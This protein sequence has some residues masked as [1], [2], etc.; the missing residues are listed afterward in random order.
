[1]TKNN[2]TLQCDERGAIMLLGLFFA[3][4]GAAIVYSVVGVSQALLYRQGL[5]DGADAGA[6]SAAVME[7]RLM[8]AIVLVNIL[9][10]AILSVLVALK[11]VELLAIMGMMLATALAYP[12]FGASLAAIPVLTPIQQNV[13]S[14]HDQLEDPISEGIKA[15]YNVNFYLREYGP[16]GIVGVVKDEFQ[17]Q[18]FEHPVEEG[19]LIGGDV[20]PIEDGEYS[21]LC[22]KAAKFPVAMAGETLMKPLAEAIP[23]VFAALESGMELMAE[24]FSEWF[25]GDGESGSPSMSQTEE[26]WYPQSK[27]LSSCQDSVQNSYSQDWGAAAE[28][29][30]EAVDCTSQAADAELAQPDKV[31]NCV[32]QCD[33]DGPYE[34]R[35]QLAREVC[36]PKS[37][38]RWDEYSY[39]VVE[40]SVLYEWT[41]QGW[42]RHEPDYGPVRIEDS[43]K[44]LCG[45]SRAELDPGYNPIVRTTDDVNDLDVVC[46]SERPPESEARIGRNRNQLVQFK[47]VRHV[48]GCMK[49][50]K[51]TADV[52]AQ[53]PGGFGE[54]D[55]SDES[56]SE[57]SSTEVRL[58]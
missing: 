40:G 2:S 6:L 15:L 23:P 54:S 26:V 24:T 42:V 1:M 16:K 7:A 39:Q 41:Q 52:K 5:Q 18:A 57:E 53:R 21:E 25:C 29:F 58:F 48:L 35:V 51:I 12:T 55:D 45:T 47:E 30:S 32:A 22:G 28:S 49:R 13:H 10:S 31:G 11:L 4:F 3:I 50:E 56:K 44:P 19:F 8:N 34:E 17:H 9:M 27:E 38:S 20:L 43:K 36:D 37:K 33:V 14:L 46:T